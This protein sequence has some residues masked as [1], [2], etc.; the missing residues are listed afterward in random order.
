MRI[1]AI[2]CTA[3]GA[4]LQAEENKKM[5]YCPYCGTKIVLDD[6][7]IEIT[8]R[9]VDEARLKEAEIRLKELEYA[10]QR[11][12]REEEMRVKQK[13]THGMYIGIFIVTALFFFVFFRDYFV[14]AVVIGAIILG[15]LGTSDNRNVKKAYGASK[16]EKNRM[17]ALILCIFVGE[18]GVHYFYVG[19]IGTGILYLCTFGLFGFGWLVDI[20]RIAAGIF[21]DKKG[22]ILE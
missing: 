14:G 16:S 13:K 21:R 3:C 9:I 17:V 2:R 8:N 5:L 15:I 4:D 20:V 11:E 10:H 19:K 6:D 22:Y 12:L 18:F 1:T 7:N